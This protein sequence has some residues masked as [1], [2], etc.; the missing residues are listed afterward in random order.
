MRRGL[1]FGHRASRA[2]SL[3]SSLPTALCQA[4]IAFTIE[5]DNE[6]EHRVEHHTGNKPRFT[7][8]AAPSPPH[9]VGG[10]PARDPRGARLRS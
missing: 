10:P 9:R 6:L 7:A 1:G 3:T 5:F 8:A 4:L 2:S